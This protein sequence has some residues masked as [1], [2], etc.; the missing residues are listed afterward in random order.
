MTTLTHEDDQH[1]GRQEFLDDL[2]DAVDGLQRGLDV[3]KQIITAAAGMDPAEAE[4][5]RR[6]R[7][8]VQKLRARSKAKRASGGGR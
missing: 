5:R 1:E 4:A 6:G 3:L 2:A 8:A 7:E